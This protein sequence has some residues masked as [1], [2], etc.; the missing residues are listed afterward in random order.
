MPLKMKKIKLRKETKKSVGH[1][2]KSNPTTSK[3][4]KEVGQ[5]PAEE[6]VSV[7]ITR[8]GPRKN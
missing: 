7:L 6:A 4:G 2:R 5:P 1:K 8:S 3:Y